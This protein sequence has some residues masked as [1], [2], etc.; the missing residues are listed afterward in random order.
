MNQSGTVFS[1][2]IVAVVVVTLSACQGDA[3]EGTR[4]AN[5]TAEELGEVGAKVWLEPEETDDILDTYDL[6]MEEFEQAVND[7]SSNSEKSRQY[8]RSFTETRKQAE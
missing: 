4:T 5:L 3:N 6:T 7:V 8:S 1:F 2:L